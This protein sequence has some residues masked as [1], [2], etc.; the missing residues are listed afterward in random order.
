MINKELEYRMQLA[1]KICSLTLSL[2]KK[3]NIRVRQ[4][5]EKIMIPVADTHHQQQIKAVESLI[6]NEVNIKGIEYL[7]ESSNKLVKKIKPNFK[8][9]GPKY[10]QMMKAIAAV[11]GS[12]EQAE[13]TELERNKSL[14]I[15]VENIDIDITTEDVEITTEDIPGWVVATEGG[16]TV[17]LD[18]VITEPL[19]HEGIARDMVN[20]IQNLRKENG[21]EVTDRIRLI[22]EKRDEIYNAINNNRQYICSETLTGELVWIEKAES[23]DMHIFDLSEDIMVIMKIEKI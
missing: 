14:K 2:R 12:M 10:G 17:A 15:T 4:P 22:I 23:N 8:I 1:Q 20:R 3:N 18:V 21:L 11:V 19:Y 16:L 9:L 13:I 7:T 6:L 5:L